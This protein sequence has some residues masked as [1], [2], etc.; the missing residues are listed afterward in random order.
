MQTLGYYNGSYGSLE[1]MTVPM[2]DR[3]CYFGDGVYDASYSRNYKIFALDEHIDRFFDSAAAL[4]LKLEQSKEELGGVLNEMMR[5]MDSGECF[6]YWQAT[7]GA[8][9]RGHAYP[10]PPRRANLWIMLRPAGV[11]PLDRR[12]KLI[13]AED[14]RYLH[15]NI[16]TLNLLVN[17]M[18]AE[19]AKRAG[20]DEAV[21]HRGGRVTEGTSKNCHIIKDGVFITAPTD[22]LILAGVARAHLL[23][24]CAALG[25]PTEVRPFTL[26]ELFAAH[27][28]VMSSAGCFGLAA[29]CIDGR[30]VGGNAPEL[31]ARLHRY[32]WDEFIAETELGSAAT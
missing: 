25:I 14:T 19:R 22:H 11:M 29:E 4:E 7:R 13:T 31:L 10:D 12:L 8:A 6:V 30:P 1:E 17:C 18:A 16:K 26:E 3:A 24:A 23:R 28:V 20:A 27:E 32:L 2:T 15:C 21:F 9:L 5:K